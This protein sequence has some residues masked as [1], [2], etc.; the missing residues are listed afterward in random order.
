MLPIVCAL[1][2]VALTSC[3][4]VVDPAPVAT[5]TTVHSEQRVTRPAQATTTTTRTT[6]AT[7]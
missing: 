5:T 2:L 6:G 4:T 3:T 1:G 7:Y